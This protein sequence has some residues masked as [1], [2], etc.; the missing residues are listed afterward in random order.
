MNK[1]FKMSQKRKSYSARI[2]LEII[3]FA[4]IEGNSEAAR[5]YNVNECNIRKW[6]KQKSVLNA[7]N[8]E[9]RARRGREAFWK[10]LEKNLKDWI[11]NLR[12]KGFQVLPFDIKIKAKAMAQGMKIEEFKASDC[13]CNKFMKGNQLS[14][15]SKTSQGHNE[16]EDWEEKIESFKSYM[17]DKKKGVQLVN[18]GNIDEVPVSFDLPG[19]FNVDVKGSRQ[20]RVLT[21]GNEKCNFT[22]ALC[23][24]ADGTKLPP[25]IIFKRKNIPEGD[26]PKGVIIE[27]NEK[28][29]MNQDM[30][31]V[32][33]N[34]V[35]N[36]RKSAFF[37]KPKSLLIFD[38]APSHRTDGVK[39][40]IKK[41]I[42]KCEVAVI[43]G[44]LTKRLQP[45]DISVNKFF[46]MKLKRKWQNWII[47]QYEVY[48]ENKRFKRASYAEVVKW[49]KQSWD[50]I[51]VDCI[52]NGFKTAMIH[53]YENCQNDD[54]D[55]EIE[56]D[57]ND[58]EKSIPDELGELLNSFDIDSDDENFQGFD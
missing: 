4:L 56:V 1:W 40:F 13:W 39:D 48:K 28:G 43:P 53:S 29:W 14:V 42:P 37:S 21:T 36:N 57:V 58:K 18:L 10:D 23:V 2:K 5:R 11:V 32:W 12:S 45:L 55:T 46:K 44:G 16:P 17:M 25:F 22:A 50:E 30:F 47:E 3:E 38:A 9:K 49:I 41:Y 20:V 51:T 34:K 31:K 52:K 7:M 35:W 19:N 33:L 26:F 54:S 8:R 6:I 15:R 24:C 27:A